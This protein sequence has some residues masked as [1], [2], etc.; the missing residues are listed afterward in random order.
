MTNNNEFRLIPFHIEHRSLTQHSHNTGSS[1]ENPTDLHTFLTA[2]T[3]PRA[4]SE[5]LD[6]E[7]HKRSP[8]ASNE[9]HSTNT[10]TK[11]HLPNAPSIS[12]ESDR[13]ALSSCRNNV[14]LNIVDTAIT[15]TPYRTPLFAAQSQCLCAVKVNTKIR[16]FNQKD[17]DATS[18]QEFPFI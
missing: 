11:R 18:R 4:T 7:P 5:K 16:L 14:N 1:D 15:A 6:T 10:Q 9:R 3:S 13:I 2:A 12:A 17:I 8:V